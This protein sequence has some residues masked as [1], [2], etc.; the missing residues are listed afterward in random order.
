MCFHRRLQIETDYTLSTLGSVPTLLGS[1]LDLRQ[2]EKGPSISKLD[3][4][5]QFLTNVENLATP[6][7]EAPL[8]RSQPTL[9]CIYNRTCCSKAIKEHRSFL[10][11][12]PDTGRRI[13]WRSLK[14]D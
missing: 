5:R 12:I 6:T 9:D 7:G 3:G 14:F 4:N 2:N 11:G 8:K 13:R 10:N 1:S